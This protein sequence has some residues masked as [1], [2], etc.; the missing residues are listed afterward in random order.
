MAFVIDKKGN[1]NNNK[2][3]R[4]LELEGAL[5]GNLDTNG[6]QTAF[7]KA[8]GFLSGISEFSEYSSESER[9]KDVWSDSEDEAPKDQIEAHT[10]KWARILSEKSKRKFKNRIKTDSKLIK[11]NPKELK[12]DIL[13]VVNIQTF[14]N[15]GS[16]KVF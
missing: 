15:D 13:S 11:E 3:S 2:S 12:K 8:N 9:P 7:E 6:E 5:L 4:E 16:K 1:L 10:P 14:Y